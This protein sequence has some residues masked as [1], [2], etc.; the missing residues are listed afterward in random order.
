[1]SER[2]IVNKK[3]NLTNPKWYRLI[4]VALSL[5]AFESLSQENPAVLVIPEPPVENVFFALNCST[6]SFH[7]CPVA[8]LKR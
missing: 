8:A 1:M 7:A 5:F 4:A 6:L 3:L 2:F